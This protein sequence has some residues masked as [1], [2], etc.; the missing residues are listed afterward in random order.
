MKAPYSQGTA[1]LSSPCLAC[2]YTTA[3]IIIRYER[4]LGFLRCAK[5]DS[6]QYS[7]SDR[8]AGEVVA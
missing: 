4:D 5:C 6:P 3:L 7:I 1:P 8:Q 2:G